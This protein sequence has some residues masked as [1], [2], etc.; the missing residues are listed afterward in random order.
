[1][2]NTVD[3]STRSQC[4]SPR[5]DSKGWKTT[6]AA[7]FAFCW[8]I[9]GVACAK[10][11]QAPTIGESVGQ[12]DKTSGQTALGEQAQAG[13]Q[14]APSLVTTTEK[15]AHSPHAAARPPAPENP[16]QLPPP[17]PCGPFT[18]YRLTDPGRAVAA[19]VLH[20]KAQLIG[21]GEAH[22]PAH[23]SGRTTVAR[24]TE[25]VLPALSTGSSHLM[26]E[27]LAPPAAGCDAEK[28][29]ARKESDAVTQG[30]SQANQNQYLGLGNR[31]RELGVV[32]DILRASCADMEQIAAPDGGVL[33]YMET[34]ARLFAVN[35][36]ERLKKTK[37]GRPLVLAYGGALHNDAQ[38]RP[39]RESW[40]Y[41]ASVQRQTDARY[42][43][44]DLLIPELIGDTESWKSFAWYSTYA[45]L[46]K[47][48]LHPPGQTLL[49]KWGQSSYA[50]F[51]S[52]AAAPAR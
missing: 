32:P 27:L 39:G 45:K 1:M 36:N 50:L 38:P 49:M 40:S 4:R 8:G 28:E 13:V 42:L 12:Q 29:A 24:F 16:P 3:R 22:A 46:Q 21:F 51:F 26:V 7:V 35:L 31:A 6:G 17:E 41:V 43:E 9:S 14:P 2:R 25:E 47:A 10:P 18:C 5:G 30:Q 23:F 15:P 37:P 11:P 48:G 52:P 33:A 34:I 20:E 44:L 19:V